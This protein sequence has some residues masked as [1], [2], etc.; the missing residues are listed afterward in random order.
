MFLTAHHPQGVPHARLR[1]VHCDSI[2]N[3]PLKVIKCK[4]RACW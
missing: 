4:Q 1:A 2:S 3:S